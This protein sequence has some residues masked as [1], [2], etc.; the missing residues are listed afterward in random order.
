MTLK[1]EVQKQTFQPD[2]KCFLKKAPFSVTI[3]VD[4]FETKGKGASLGFQ[5]FIILDFLQP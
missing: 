5:G 3:V 4:Q 1:P 2:A